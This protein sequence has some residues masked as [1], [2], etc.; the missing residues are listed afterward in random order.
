MTTKATTES[1]TTKQVAEAL[2][3]DPKTLRVFLRASA[4]YTA[5]G[6]QQAVLVHDQG[7]RPDEDPVRQVD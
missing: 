2:G 1:L 6:V 7:C 3:T 4:D 5:V